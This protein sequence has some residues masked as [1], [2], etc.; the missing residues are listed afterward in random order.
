MKKFLIIASFL[1]GPLCTFSQTNLQKEEID[2]LNTV[3]AQKVARV[4]KTTNKS[5]SLIL[6]K[7][8]AALLPNDPSIQLLFKV[9][10]ATVK[11]EQ[12]DGVGIAA[13]QIGISR[14]I[15]L[16]QRFDKNEQPFEA[17]LNPMIIWK[18]NLIQ[19]GREGCLSI[20]D[21]MGIVDRHYCIVV[22]Y[23][24]LNGQ[25][26]EEMLEGF[27]AIIFQH[28]FDHLNGILFLDRLQ[29]QTQVNYYNS[30]QIFKYLSDKNT[31]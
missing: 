11:D 31:R 12:N 20:P 7:P 19:N 14:S 29:Q 8:T 15:F 5:D 16:L 6:R 21:T 17:I 22:K 28:E 4:L 2:I 30:T 13:P 9:L 23:Q 3:N 18:S 27:T 10:L 1:L 24:Q 26:I 25:W